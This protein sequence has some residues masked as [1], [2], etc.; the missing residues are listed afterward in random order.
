MFARFINDLADEIKN[1]NLGLPIGDAK[2]ALLMY[3][4]DIVLLNRNHT[5]AQTSLDI[6]SAWCARWGMKIN[7]AKY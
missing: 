1:V 3:A 2:L 6:L 4:D 7:I 5:D